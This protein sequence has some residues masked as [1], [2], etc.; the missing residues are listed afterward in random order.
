MRPDACGP[1]KPGTWVA[2]PISNL[3]NNNYIKKNNA[4][5]HLL[6]KKSILKK[7]NLYKIKKKNHRR[8]ILAFLKTKYIRYHL[9]ISII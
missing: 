9:K 7:I 4:R 2:K 3:L 6:I 8:F 1:G 5:L